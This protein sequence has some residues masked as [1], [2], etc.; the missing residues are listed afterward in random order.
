MTH[1]A[2]PADGIT[3]DA[4]RR[5]SVAELARV[6]RAG[7][8]LAIVASR[9]A[10]REA[11]VRFIRDALLVVGSAALGTSLGYFGLAM[12]AGAMARPGQEPWQ[13]G[14]GQYL[15][16]L[17]CGA[18]LGALAGVAAGVARIKTRED[19]AAW[20]IAAWAGILAGLLA[21]PALAAR[22]GV[23]RGFGWWG[24]AVLAAGCATLGGLLGSVLAAV[25]P[26]DRRGRR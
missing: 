6:R 11:L 12:L 18:P 23:H 15:G 13:T 8:D 26:A 24:T 19:D 25:A 3:F 16:G 14:F 21:G 17:F 1:A 22:L 10:W 5:P 2:Q 9:S 20:G 4:G 7:D